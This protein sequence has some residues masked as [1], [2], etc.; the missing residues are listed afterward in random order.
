MIDSVDLSTLQAQFAAALRYQ[1]SDIER[2]VL[3]GDLAAQ[4]VIQL[5][6]NNFIISCSEALQASYPVVFK[7][8]GEDFFNQAARLWVL[9]HP[10]QSGNIIDYGAEFPAWLA[11]WPPAASL[12]Y[13][14]DVAKFEWLIEQTAVAEHVITAF[15]FSQ[16]ANVTTAQLPLL[17]F[18]LALQCNVYASDYPV[19]QIYQMVQQDQVEAIEMAQANYVLLHKQ[20][21]FQVHLHR[22]SAQEYHFLNACQQGLSLTDISEQFDFDP[23]PYIQPFI[24]QGVLNQFRLLGEV[25]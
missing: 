16:L 19:H 5:Y 9:A 25:T 7:L 10:P 3:S 4:Q 2:Q 6:R 21:N 20:A 12:P 1:A 22:L 18:Q 14:A 23:S 8:V 17:Q 15:P 13:L 11:Q 24:A